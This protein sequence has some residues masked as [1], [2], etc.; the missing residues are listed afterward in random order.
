M[1]LEQVRRLIVLCGLRFYLDFTGDVVGVMKVKVAYS[2]LRSGVDSRKGS[3]ESFASFLSLG[4]SGVEAV[5]FSF[6]VGVVGNK[7]FCSSSSL[8]VATVASWEQR[9]SKD[10]KND[11]VNEAELVKDGRESVREPSGEK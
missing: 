2:C 1:Y 10:P 7:S 6:F 4:V 5:R 8:K 9:V 11:E 3:M